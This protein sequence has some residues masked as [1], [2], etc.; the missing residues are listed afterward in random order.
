MTRAYFNGVKNISSNGRTISFVLDD[1][2]ETRS[3]GEVRANVAELITEIETAEEILKYI[4]LEI[5]KIKT[6]K[7]TELTTPTLA[8]PSEDK[9]RKKPPI[10]RQIKTFSIDN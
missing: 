5:E 6:L 4:L 2:Y 10:G 1:Y 9:N 8:I 3:Q 7:R